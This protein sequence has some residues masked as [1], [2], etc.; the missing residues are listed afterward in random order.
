MSTA[1]AKQLL[2]NSRTNSFKTCRKRHWWEYEIGFRKETDAKALRMGTAGHEGLDLLKRGE[3]LGSAIEAISLIYQ[4]CPEGVDEWDW[5]IERETIESLVAGYK[6]RWE[7][8]DITVLANEESFQL[9]LSN[10][11]TGS[12]SKIWDLAGKIDGI[13]ELEDKRNAVMEHK[14]L[15]E[16]LDLNS[17]LWRRLQMD[18]QISI[19]VHAARRKGWQGVETI[20]Y[21]AI[22]KPA[23]KPVQVPI[24]DDNEFKI[25]LD[26]NGERVLTKQGKPRE[27]ASKGDGYVLQS[28]QMTPAEWSIKLLADIGE[29]PDFY[30][31]RVEI[32]RLDSDI[33]EMLYELWDIQKTMREAQRSDRW[34]KTVTRNSCPFC[35]FFGLCSSRFDPAT[36]EVPEGFVKVTSIHPELDLEESE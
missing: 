15:G 32:A 9:P 5:Q 11:A 25:V 20:L 31:A 36:G 30:F 33:E 24:R 19:Y 26:R 7:S 2:T 3:P 29:R 12:V 10:P 22:R 16:D 13:V 6:W 28:R 27:T 8:S 21:D 4:H 35:A 23:I 18:S 14:F 34:Y 1:T 17:D